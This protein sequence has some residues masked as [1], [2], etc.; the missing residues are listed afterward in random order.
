MPRSCSANRKRR[1]DDVDAER[2]PRDAFRLQD[3]ADLLRR[4]LEEAR[5]RRHGAAQAHE[6]RERLLLGIHGA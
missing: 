6:A 3:V 2:H 1:L 5:L 4:L